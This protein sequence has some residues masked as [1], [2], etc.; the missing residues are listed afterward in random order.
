MF[1]IGEFELKFGCAFLEFVEEDDLAI[2]NI[3]P[4]GLS[5]NRDD[6]VSSCLT[7]EEER[8]VFHQKV[9]FEIFNNKN[10]YNIEYILKL[11]K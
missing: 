6:F 4:I 9:S 8:F 1:A 2:V 3:G 11:V 10:K 5:K 7:R